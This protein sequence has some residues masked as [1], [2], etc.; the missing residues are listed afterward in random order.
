MRHG[1]P[2]QEAWE[3][4]LKGVSRVTNRLH[5]LWLAWTYPFASIGKDV[6]V[7]R[8]CDL[9]RSFAKYIR[10]GDDVKLDRNVWIN[11]PEIP[12]NDEPVIIL[13]DGCEI[14]RGCVIS[15]KNRIHIKRNTIFGPSVFVTDHN[16]AFE[17]VTVPIGLQGIT[18][19]G[20]VRIEEGSWVGFGAAVVCSRG[21]LV[22][23]RNSIIGANSVLSRSVNSYSVVTGNPA[24]TVKHYDQAKDAWVLG[25]GAADG[26]R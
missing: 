18:Q 25:M 19:G 13:E 7:H 11:I 14:G 24:R 9:Q 6:W 3:D 16:H 21:E 23:G 12:N 15:A 8:S 22:I 4:P 20:T 10:I 5:T 2:R 17:D 26:Q 1:Q